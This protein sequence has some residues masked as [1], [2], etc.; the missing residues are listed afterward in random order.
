[1]SGQVRSGLIVASVYR[2][3]ADRDVADVAAN[4]DRIQVYVSPAGRSVRVFWNGMEV[5]KP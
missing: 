5:A 1:M 2:G 4:R 3:L